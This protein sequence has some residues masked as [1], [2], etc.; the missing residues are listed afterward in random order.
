[1]AGAQHRKP[2]PLPPR[3]YNSRKLES[4]A[5]AGL[6]NPDTDL[7]HGYLNHQADHL[8]LEESSESFLVSRCC[9]HMILPDNRCD[10]RLEG[11]PWRSTGIRDMQAAL[12]GLEPCPCLVPGLLSLLVF[13]QSLLLMLLVLVLQP[14]LPLIYQCPL[15]DVNIC[16]SPW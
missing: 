10:I 5:K 11:E 12:F 16:Y 7:R 14:R 13:L 6:S 1:M 8:P 4:G 2:T 3:M 15:L 9:G